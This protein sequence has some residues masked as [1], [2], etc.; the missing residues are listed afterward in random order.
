MSNSTQSS[1]CMMKCWLAAAALGGLTFVLSL[2]G[3]YSF[4]SAIFLGAL[5]F[6]LLGLLF[7]W[8]YCGKQPEQVTPAAA[9]PAKPVAPVAEA[10]PV[11]APAA[12]ETKAPEAK[13][14]DAVVKPSKPLAGEAELANRKGEWTYEADATAEEETAVAAP[15][16]AAQPVAE[17][18]A[19][20]AGPVI[21]PSKA[22][23]GEAELAERK[24][25]WKY[26]PE[27]K[28][29][30]KAAPAAE[31]PKVQPSKPLSG[32]AELAARKGDYKYEAEAAETEGVKP[33][34]LAEAREG[35]PDD[36]K[37]IKGIGPKLQELCFELGYYHFDQIASWTAE[38]VAWV[39]QN[40]KGFRGR[41][42]RDNWVEQAKLLASGGETE[43]SKRV[44]KG[45][46]Y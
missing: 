40:L 33:E 44:D 14:D 25:T 35:G 46:V 10:T 24:G 8:L 36:L 38:E 39:D 1:G 12:A 2:V 32:E 42:T 29:A 26:E 31:A 30:A 5:A 7:S 9:A 34:G 17:A 3:H 45:G 21:K 19:D 28:P 18:K 13:A 23:S 27:P 41:V 16:P 20:E 6:I 37:R 43:F 4:V 22:L 11:A 15:A